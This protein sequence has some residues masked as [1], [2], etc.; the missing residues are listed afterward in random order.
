LPFYALVNEFG[1]VDSSGPKVDGPIGF[2]SGLLDADVSALAA[3]T[4]LGTVD[5]AGLM[6]EDSDF[7]NSLG[8]RCSLS[9]ALTL[10]T[11]LNYSFT[12]IP[13]PLTLTMFGAG[14]AG[15][16]AATRKRRRTA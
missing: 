10:T 16:G 13:E 4:G 2:G 7:C 3:Y 1:S 8:T 14:F 9:N 15:I 11:T 6:S 12:P 5:V